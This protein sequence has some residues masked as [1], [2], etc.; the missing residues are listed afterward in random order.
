MK[1]NNA[2]LES[3][4]YGI[5][6]RGRVAKFENGNRNGKASQKSTSGFA[7]GMIAALACFSSMLFHAVMTSTSILH[8]RAVFIAFEIFVFAIVLLALFVDALRGKK[9]SIASLF[10]IGALVLIVLSFF[11]DGYG[12]LYCMERFLFFCAFGVVGFMGGLLCDKPMRVAQFLKFSDIVWILLTLGSVSYLFFT[13]GGIWVP[14]DDSG[15]NYQT[16]A[17]ASALA[18]GINF[19][20]L[21]SRDRTSG[22]RFA[23]ARTRAFSIASICAGIVQA[24][25]CVFSGG[26]GGLVLFCIY[27][28]AFILFYA[29]RSGFSLSKLIVLAVVTLGI[30]WFIG[31]VQANADFGGF[32][33]I[34]R[35]ML[36]G[37]TG[38]EEIYALAI[39]LIA[40]NPFVGYGFYGYIPFLGASYPHNIVLQWLLSFGI[41]GTTVALP[42][43]VWCV[44]SIIR[45]S[46]RVPECGL[47]LIIL[48]YSIVILMFSGSFLESSPFMFCMAFATCCGNESFC[49]K[50]EKAIERAQIE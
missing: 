31:F 15:M 44:V 17:Y 9:F 8:S 34:R 7:V 35:T 18:F 46:Y 16:A 20:L 50:A 24:F 25:C 5:L 30:F 26:R 42:A 41:V 29:R 6:S 47:V 39:S 2:R 19:F 10:A 1:T 32:D 4:G 33:R 48:L 36:G 12:N 38:R 13:E 37:Y 45:V 28:V 23:F 14:R 21:L 27:C 43:F 49:L 40:E 11:L 3:V 22:F